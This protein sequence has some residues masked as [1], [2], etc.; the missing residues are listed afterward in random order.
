MKKL[1]SRNS[2]QSTSQKDKKTNLKSLTFKQSISLLVLATL[3]L[4][5]ASGYYWYQN[6]FTNP[7]RVLSGMLDKSLQT[8]NVQRQVS[9]S[10]NSNSLDQ[11]VYL[12]FSPDTLSNSQTVLT[13]TTGQGKT[14]VTTENLGTPNADYVRYTDIDVSSNQ[15]KR[16]FDNIIGVWGKRDNKPETGEAASFLKDA[17][18]SVVPFGNLDNSQRNEIKEEIKK[19]NLYQYRE[20]KTEYKNGRPV[21]TYTIDLDPQALVTVLSKHAEI[22]GVGGGSELN[23]AM[24][25]GAQKVPVKLEVDLLSRHVANVEF[26]GSGRAEVYRAYNSIRQ[27]E[28]PEDTIGI[29]E[30]QNRL[31]E[32]E[33]RS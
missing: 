30:L 9:Q 6:V 17:L 19:T 21:M 24:Y 23:P 20:A 16:N 15:N 10:D 29:D 13:E 12:S 32:L 3:F 18:F 27:I 4:F 7:D 26:L 1:F 28:V 11:A 31:Q 5:G 14:M 8:V 25:E 22:T 33:K 2:K